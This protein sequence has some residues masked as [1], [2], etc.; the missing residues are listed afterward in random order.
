MTGSLRVFCFKL[1]GPQVYYREL[2]TTASTR[3]EAEARLLLVA[4]GPGKEYVYPPLSPL[5]LQMASVRVFELP[6][7]YCVLGHGQG[8]RTAFGGE[9]VPGLGDVVP[10]GARQLP[11]LD[12]A[13]PSGEVRVMC[14]WVDGHAAGVEW[15]DGHW[16]PV[17]PAPASGMVLASSA[18]ARPELTE[19][20]IA[21]YVYLVEDQ[22]GGRWPR[23]RDAKF[24]ER[25]RSV[26]RRLVS[27]ADNAAS[28]TCRDR[29]R[30]SATL[31]RA[32]DLYVDAFCAGRPLALVV[33]GAPGAPAASG[34]GLVARVEDARGALSEWKCRRCGYDWT[35]RGD[36]PAVCRLCRFRD[37]DAAQG[38]ALGVLRKRTDVCDLA[39]HLAARW[40]EILDTA[41]PGSDAGFL[42]SPQQVV[43]VVGDLGF[44]AKPN[45]GR[46]RSGEPVRKTLAWLARKGLLERDGDGH[47]SRYRMP[48]PSAEQVEAEV[49][50]E[51]LR[52]RLEE[53]E[54]RGDAGE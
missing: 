9:V 52:V 3:A 6:W 47:R 22:L 42:I 45:G 11:D 27:L 23:S 41:V 48:G 37:L 50:A 32:H 33:E 10:A 13:E 4:N 49:A 14:R 15:V 40:G 30:I 7:S 34:P 28:L 31:V 53:A 17:S 2:Y 25:L 29:A 24:H 16:E 35:A 51:T 39:K 12:A 18:E 38:R 36:M 26:V 1:T 19:E 46:K 44:D 54:A 43:E 21:E 5:D 20:E 8:V